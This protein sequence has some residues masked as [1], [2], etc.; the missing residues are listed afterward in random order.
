MGLLSITDEPILIVF[1]NHTAE[2]YL[3]NQSIYHDILHTFLVINNNNT[4]AISLKL[5]VF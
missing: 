3:N 2:L 4:I 1:L 5:K